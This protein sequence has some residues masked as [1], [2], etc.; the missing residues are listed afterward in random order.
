MAVGSAVRLRL[1]VN[2]A[3]G[4]MRRGRLDAAVWG[5][6]RGPWPLELYKSRSVGHVRDLAA[7]AA[8]GGQCAALVVAGGDGTVSAAVAG[9]LGSRLPLGVLPL[10]TGNDFA[11]ALG[12]PADPAA[13]A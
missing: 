7:E 10:G 2:P 6:S 11:S 9:L 5:L 8:A 4:G 13:A 12:L 1:V 3:A